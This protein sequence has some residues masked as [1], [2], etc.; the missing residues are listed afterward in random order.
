[1]DLYLF[2]FDKTLYAYNFRLRLP[3]FARLGGE[4]QYH[5]AS[6]WW[7]AGY[8]TRAESGEWPTADEYLAEFGRVTGAEL[9]LEQ[10]AHARA[11][12]MTRIDGSV[13]ALR[14]ASGLGTVSLLSNNPSVF[15]A[16]LPLIAP[17]VC[18]IV[19]ENRLISADLGVRKPDPL[20]YRLALERYGAD[21]ADTFFTDDNAENVAGAAAVGI[22]AHLF[23]TP[24]LL[25]AAITTF[26]ERHQ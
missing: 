24:E 25:D 26:S 3:E 14:R 21:A 12:A 5:L 4:S 20:V 13:D 11:L 2:D 8:E 9:T 18:A 17:D 23:T 6:T 1:M 16:A 15:A 22:H 10:W 7:A 19:G